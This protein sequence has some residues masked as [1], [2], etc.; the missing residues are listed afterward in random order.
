M[1]HPVQDH[2]SAPPECGSF[3]R[4]E[5]LRQARAPKLFVP[6][7]FPRKAAQPQLLSAAIE[8]A[9]LKVPSLS[10]ALS[11]VLTMTS[12]AGPASK[13]EQCVVSRKIATKLLINS[14]GRLGINAMTCVLV[15]EELRGVVVVLFTFF[16]GLIIGFE[17][18]E[19]VG[20]R[21]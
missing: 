4:Q 18:S 12:V 16:V 6:E 2:L 20:A 19:L 8:I 13:L 3:H 10:G 1:V 17:D 9:T 5:T 7:R 14:R 21:K 15:A 11:P